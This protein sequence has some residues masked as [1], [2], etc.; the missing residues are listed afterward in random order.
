MAGSITVTTSDLG[1]GITKYSVAW[2][3]DGAGAVSSN[4]FSMKMGSIVAVEFIPDGGATAPDNLYDVDLLDA[5]GASMFSDGAASPASIGA[6]LSGTVAAHRVP[7]IFGAAGTTYVR[8]WLHGGSYQPT[9][10]AAGAANG[11]T[12]IIFVADGIV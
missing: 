3:S 2:L 8:S 10:A 9:V 12:I 4:T 5:E 6:N 7:F 1:S 11:G